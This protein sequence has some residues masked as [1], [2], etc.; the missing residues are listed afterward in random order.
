MDYL[1]KFLKYAKIN[2]KNIV[3]DIKE[4][5][6]SLKEYYLI[7]L[8]FISDINEED[9]LSQNNFLVKTLREFYNENFND[10]ETNIGNYA[11]FMIDYKIKLLSDNSQIFLSLIFRTIFSFHRNLE[12]ALKE[13]EKCLIKYKLLTK[14]QIKASK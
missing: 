10:N 4:V 2:E 6:L 5:D 11:H 8:P 7:L 3:K 12:G 14:K 13:L 9:I 1:A